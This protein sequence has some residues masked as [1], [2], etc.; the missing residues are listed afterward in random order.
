MRLLDRYVKED[1]GGNDGKL[2]RRKGNSRGDV[3]GEI[4]T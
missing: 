4:R 1:N 2:G 3:L